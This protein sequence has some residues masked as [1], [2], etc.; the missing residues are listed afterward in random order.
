MNNNTYWIIAHSVIMTS[1]FFASVYSRDTFLSVV[2][3]V[4]CAANLICLIF[5]VINHE[6]GKL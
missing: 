6:A 1:C 5:R 4:A 3:G 2:H